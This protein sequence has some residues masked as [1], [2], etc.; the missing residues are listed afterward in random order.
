MT[1]L[2][3]QHIGDLTIEKDTRISGQITGS[4]R[5]TG[6][7][8][9]IVGGH[10]AGDLDVEVGSEALIRGMVVGRVRGDGRVLVA[11]GAFLNGLVMQAD[12]TWGKPP[13][14]VHIHNDS[15]VFELEAN[16]RETRNWIT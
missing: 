14:S 5:V 12:G 9:V 4:V 11:E 8:H 16:R 13:E 10:V 3:G 6:G 15:P 7:A 1:N 2:R